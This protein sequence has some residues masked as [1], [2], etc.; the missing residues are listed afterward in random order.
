MFSGAAND[1]L[2]KTAFIVAITAL[3]WDVFT[4]NPVVLA[5]AAA[6]C[7]ILPFVLLAGFAAHQTNVQAPKRWLMILKTVELKYSH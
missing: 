3:S 4:L 1:N 2:V 5:N 7:F 6:L